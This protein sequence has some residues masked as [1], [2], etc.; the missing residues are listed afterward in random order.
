MT[1]LSRIPPDAALAIGDRIF[2]PI[3]L[4]P[5]ADEMAR[6]LARLSM[7]PLLE[8]A[9]GSG[10]LT[11]AIASALS[12]GLTIIATDP[13]AEM[14]AHASGKPG[15][16]R[17]AWQ[18]ADPLALPFHDAT[19]GV[20][21]CQFAVA[22]M[23]D[24]VRAFQQARRVIKPGGR[25]V[26]N[27]LAGIHH[28]PVADCLQ[29]ALYDLF[30]DDPPHFIARDLHGYASTPAIDDDLTAAGFTDA[31][32]TTVELPFAAAS[33]REVAIGYCRGTRLRTEL[34]SRTFGDP[35]PIL[36]AVT[37]AL[38]KRFGTGAINSSMRA[39]FISASG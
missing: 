37:L 13:S 8:I 26:F 4:S 18:Q 2:A 1:F 33:A 12:A 9:A 39:H 14:I 30:P 16:A 34:D 25:F 32:Y 28:T 23:P 29:T 3:L 38:Q 5:F 22:M 17:V 27:V 6:R 20:V 31:I 19:F 7:G 36:Q 15:M 24:R 11:Q 10:E 21:T 35:E